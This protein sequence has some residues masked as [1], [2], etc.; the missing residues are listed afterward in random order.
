M[1]R[2]RPSGPSVQPVA[3]ARSVAESQRSFASAKSGRAAVAPLL[4]SCSTP[5]AGFSF[6][7]V[8]AVS[9]QALSFNFGDPTAAGG[10][11]LAGMTQFAGTSAATFVG[12]D[13][14]ASGQL[15]GIQ[16]D[17]TGMIL[18]VFTNGQTRA[19]GQVAVATAP[20]AD[21]MERVGGN[22][23]SET[24]ASG[25]LVV[26][27]AGLYFVGGARIGK[28]Y[29][30][31][32]GRLSVPTDAASIARGKHRVEVLFGHLA[33][34]VPPH[35]LLGER[36]DNRML[37]LGAAAG[38]MTGLGAERPARHDRSFPCRN[39]MLV[40]QRLG[41]V[42]VDS[43]QILEAE[44]VSAVSAVPHTLL[45]HQKFLPTQPR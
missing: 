15:S 14:W 7:P 43:G 27:A 32:D 4:P 39:G 1:S 11:G 33:V 3:A 40:E 31:P 29:A 6:T 19:L 23:Y 34:V 16:F 18:G 2:R 22:L 44:F 35:R 41:E 36:I 37:V 17:K 45:L 12:Q 25:Q 8:G 21:Q 42:P 28:R 38:V 26:G 24:R 9:P 5:A 20:A 13:G 10:T 30:V